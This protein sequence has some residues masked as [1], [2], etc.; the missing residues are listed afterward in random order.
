MPRKDREGVDGGVDEV[1]EAVCE[2]EQHHHLQSAAAV[3]FTTVQI[4]LYEHKNV[5]N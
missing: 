2:V 1:E 4:V 3:T 5:P